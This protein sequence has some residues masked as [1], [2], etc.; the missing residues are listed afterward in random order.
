[1]FIWVAVVAFISGSTELL[2]GSLKFTFVC[3]YVDNTL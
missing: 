3:R 2:E 1:M